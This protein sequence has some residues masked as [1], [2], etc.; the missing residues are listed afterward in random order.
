MTRVDAS[1]SAHLFASRSSRKVETNLA[2]AVLVETCVR[3]RLRMSDADVFGQL[4]VLA[5]SP[6]LT[7][8]GFAEISGRNSPES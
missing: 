3:F 5:N 6:N 2:S 8:V 4:A 7:M 1:V